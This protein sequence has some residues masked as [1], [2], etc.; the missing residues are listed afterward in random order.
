MILKDAFLES[1]EMG[2]K[3]GERYEW[4]RWSEERE[5]ITMWELEWKDVVGL[6][7]Q[8]RRKMKWLNFCEMHQMESE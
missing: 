7:S 5:T 3:N 4:N 8:N 1:K 6:M 2:G